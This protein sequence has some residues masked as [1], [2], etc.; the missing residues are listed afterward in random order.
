LSQPLLER[1]REL[2]AIEDLTGHVKAG[3]GGLL[4]IEGPAGIGKTQLLECAHKTAVSAGVPLVSARASELEAG[5]AYGVVRQLFENVLREMDRGKRLRALAGAAAIAGPLLG[6][7]DALL[8]NAPTDAEFALRHGLYWL[9]VNLAGQ[10]PLLIA[11]DDAHWADHASLH[12]LSYLARRIEG[13]SLGVLLASRS[14]EPGADAE[15]VAGLACETVAKVVRPA[16]LSAIAVGQIV[17]RELG[18]QVSEPFIAACRRAT[19]GNPL[20]VRELVRELAEG[21]ARGSTDEAIRVDAVAPRALGSA[22]LSRVARL[23]GE[24]VAVVKAVAVLGP[25]ADPARVAV[26]TGQRQSSVR[27]AI[28]KLIELDVLSDDGRPAFVH[29][30][31][32]AGIYKEM[33]ASERTDLHA[34]AARV[35]IDAGAPVEEIAAHLLHTDPAGEE[36]VVDVLRE[37]A[38]RTLARGEARAALPYLQRAGA[39]LPAERQS[40]DL[41]LEL[42]KL[43]VACGEESGIEMLRT[44]LLTARDPRRRAVI[45]LELSMALLAANRLDDATEVVVSAVDGLM[46]ADREL[47]LLLE[48]ALHSAALNAVAPDPAVKRRIDRFAGGLAGNSP[49]ERAMLVQLAGDGLLAGASAARAVALIQPALPDHRPADDHERMLAATTAGFLILCDE[50][51]TA[52]RLLDELLSDARARGS[53]LGYA[54]TCSLRCLSARRQ[55]QIAEALADGASAIEVAETHGI[56][57]QLGLMYANYIDALVQHGEPQLALDCAERYFEFD[58]QAGLADKAA[59]LHNRAQARL[60]VGQLKGAIA[61]LQQTKDVLSSWGADTPALHQWRS[62]LSCALRL[63]GETVAARRLAYEDLELAHG[64]GTP[65]VIGI[66]LLALAPCE[67]PAR[68][69]ELLHEAADVLERSCARLE[70]AR[71]LAALGAALRRANQRSAARGRLLVALDLAHRCGSPPLEREARDELAALGTRP[72]RPAISGRDSLTASEARVAAMAADGMSNKDIAQALFVT[73]KTVET[74]LSRTYMK[75]GIGSRRE[76]TGALQ[77]DADDAKIGVAPCR[78]S[79]RDR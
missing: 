73:L 35:L 30:M 65:R 14:A 7:S 26:L 64:F 49:G 39:E 15:L 19:G 71:A 57:L 25:G 38:R 32:A 53:P 21:G 62:T 51:E 41:Q 2:A 78:E 1:E 70:Y 74:H 36:A 29:P 63:S 20:M 60:A 50:I 28:D 77:A 59:L 44:A 4:L 27:D 13:T 34:R 67:R 5:F 22:V 66:A 16:E 48:A 8:D 61:D 42:A 75:L 24:T 6:V 68:A 40:P 54:Y 11:V 23:S 31:L 47:E 76:L 79:R 9:A 33:T 72:R 46:G 10:R 37:A 69:L 58:D 43:L 55:G 52:R 56:Q 12:W 17:S 18:E 45:A 3:R